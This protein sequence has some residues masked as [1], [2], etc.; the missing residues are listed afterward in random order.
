MY[1]DSS[2]L[3]KQGELDFIKYKNFIKENNIPSS[4]LRTWNDPLAFKPHSL[5]YADIQPITGV[6]FWYEHSP[7][8]I[9]NTTLPS[10]SFSPDTHRYKKPVQ[11]IIYREERPKEQLETIEKR[12]Y[13]L[14]QEERKINTNP[15]EGTNTFRRQRQLQEEGFNTGAEDYFDKK[16]GK[17][18]GSYNK[19]TN[20][21]LPMK[22]HSGGEYSK[23]LKL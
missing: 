19:E 4:S 22:F 2:N 13:T 6:G 17:Y 5:D 16:T 8:V 1:E 21:I 14:Q 10:K 12:E 3:Y 18:I 15:F 20:K 7:D 23:R 11:P 9:S